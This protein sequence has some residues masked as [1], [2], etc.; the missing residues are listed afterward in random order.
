MQ[1]ENMRI[2][3]QVGPRQKLET[4][5]EKNKLKAKMAGGMA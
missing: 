4:L 3:G 2:A 5:S 1:G